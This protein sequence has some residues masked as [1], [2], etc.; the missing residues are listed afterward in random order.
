MDGPT[1]HVCGVA[2]GR[3]AHCASGPRMAKRCGDVDIERRAPVIEADVL[4]LA[5]R[6]DAGIV[7]QDVD[8]AEG[9]F[10]FE[11]LHV[12][13]LG[14]VALDGDGGLLLLDISGAALLV[15]EVLPDACHL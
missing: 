9:F 4:G 13:G 2:G 6:G 1:D 10:G 5:M 7:D 14:D 8:R 12:G 3:G 11:P 15:C